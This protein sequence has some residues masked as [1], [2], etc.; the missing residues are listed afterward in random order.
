MQQNLPSWNILVV[1]DDEDDYFLTRAM[2]SDISRFSVHLEWADTYQKAA[3]MLISKTWDA[4]LVDYDLGG[5]NGV[6]LIQESLS[7]GIKAPFIMIT[8]RG[9][10]EKDVEAMQAGA[11]DYL[12][13][14]ELSPPLLERAIRY[15]K[16]RQRAELELEQRVQERTADLQTALEELNVIEEELR[17]QLDEMFEYRAVADGEY[18]R[19]KDLFE[20]APIAYL[21]TDSHGVILEANTLALKLI[22]C[23]Y[24][25]LKGK[26]LSVFI[27]EEDRSLFRSSLNKLAHMI[28]HQNLGLR[29]QPRDQAVIDVDAVVSP[30]KNSDGILLAIRWLLYP[31]I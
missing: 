30:L 27:A 20:H 14:V 17:T 23:E 24:E 22:N 25:F 8:G 26:P 21:V 19:Y 15:A 6:Q 3:T 4:I 2:L 7:Q 5:K 1:D 29:L 13:K 16:E 11:F 9:S 31:K 18:Q 12:S 28:N 10:Y